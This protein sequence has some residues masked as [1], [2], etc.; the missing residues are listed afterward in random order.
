MNSKVKIQTNKTRLDM[1]L[2]QSL[3]LQ[4][5]L[6]VSL[7]GLSWTLFIGT[8]VSRI[9]SGSIQTRRIW[10]FTYRF[11]YSNTIYFDFYLG[12]IFLWAFTQIYLRVPILHA[13][14]VIPL[15]VAPEILFES[16]I[17]VEP[18]IFKSSTCI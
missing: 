8:Q 2:R 18:Q 17:R 13:S 11:P 9:R 14:V 10:W 3:V 12:P 7:V 5:N 4:L 6:N 15:S 16:Q 1:Y